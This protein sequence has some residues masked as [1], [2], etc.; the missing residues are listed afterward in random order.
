MIQKTEHG[1]RV[2]VAWIPTEFAVKNKI[3][4]ID[5][6]GKG[7]E[8]TTVTNRTLTAKQADK[9]SQLYKKTRKASDI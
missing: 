7:W 4:D 8:V 1:H 9:A 2:H 5:N 6:L 3:I